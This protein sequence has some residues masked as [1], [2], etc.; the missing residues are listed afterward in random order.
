MLTFERY[1]FIDYIK[2]IFGS[3]KGRKKNIEIIKL[4]LKVF[5]DLGF[6]DY[7]T[8]RERDILAEKIKKSRNFAIERYIFQST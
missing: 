5:K 1:L 4:T 3:K 6:R 8:Q 2:H 7:D